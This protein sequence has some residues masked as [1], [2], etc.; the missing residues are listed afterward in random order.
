MAFPTSVVRLS[1]YKPQGDRSGQVA[2]A[3]RH[4]RVRPSGSG[5][6][7]HVAPGAVAPRDVQA[8]VVV[9][10][11]AGAPHEPSTVHMGR[12]SPRGALFGSPSSRLG[13]AELGGESGAPI[14]GKPWENRACVRSSRRN[15]ISPE[16]VCRRLG[17]QRRMPQ[18]YWGDTWCF[19][20]RSLKRGSY[21]A[22]APA[23]MLQARSVGSKVRKLC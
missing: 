2:D 13:S 14:W 6:S 22:Q 7:G 11:A 10:H 21:R 4:G 1:A 20:S 19:F 8:G 16:G 9:V 15:S 23:R 3:V 5:R 12:Q 18:D 17:K